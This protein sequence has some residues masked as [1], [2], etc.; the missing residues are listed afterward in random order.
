VNEA[1]RAKGNQNPPATIDAYIAAFPPEIRRILERVRR[2]IRKAAPGAEERISYR[3]PAFRHP[4]AGIV[5]WFGGFKEHVGF[6]PPVRE[7][8]LKAKV[9]RHAGPKGNLRFRYDEPIPY[10]LIE[11]IVKARVLAKTA[12]PAKSKTSMR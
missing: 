11:E 9:A 5:A 3:M 6:Y 8:A 7:A 10:G 12:A 2:T 4:R 1:P